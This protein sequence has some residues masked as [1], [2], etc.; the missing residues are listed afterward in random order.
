VVKT[1]VGYTGGTTK[2]PTYHNIGNHTETIQIEWDPSKTTYEKLLKVF[3]NSHDS[4]YRSSTQYKSG[5]WFQSKEQEAL[6]LKSKTEQES[7]RGKKLYTVIE[8]AAVFT[9]AEDYHQKWEL[10]KHQVLLKALNLR[11]NDEIV[12]SHPAARINGYVAGDGD[13]KQ[14]MQEI[15]SFGLPTSARDYLI[16]L[17][18]RK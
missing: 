5:I 14:L 11:T 4:S 16:R 3:W 7:K 13:I 10:K 9:E 12:Q 15:D 18:D 2:N 17:V 6:A 1:R 8:P